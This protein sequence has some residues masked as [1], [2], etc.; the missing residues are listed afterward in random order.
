MDAHFPWLWIF[1]GCYSVGVLSGEVPAL[2][3]DPQIGVMKIQPYPLV[4][5]PRL[6]PHLPSC[7]KAKVGGSIPSGP[8]FGFKRVAATGYGGCS[9]HVPIWDWSCWRKTP[10]FIRLS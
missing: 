5:W 6:A 9:V 4:H 7:S 1:C 3:R 8:P 2:M 10:F